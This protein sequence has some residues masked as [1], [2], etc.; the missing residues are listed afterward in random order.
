MNHRHPD[1]RVPAGLPP[2]LAPLHLR[3][4]GAVERLPVGPPSL[5][6][7]RVLD[8]VLLPRLPDDARRA[9]EGHCVELAVTDF[10]LRVRL[11][12]APHGFA[13]AGEDGPGR[14]AA[15][16]IAASGAGYLRLLRG[17][18]DPDRLFFERTLVMEGDT[19]L[20]LVLKNTLDAIGPLWPRGAGL[21]PAARAR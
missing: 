13:S 3:L 4:R 15:L 1:R 9:L 7:A 6:A 5:L 10:G 16:R 21:R 20:G 17:E 11:R 2:F 18:D 14:E 19:E 12:I 8:R